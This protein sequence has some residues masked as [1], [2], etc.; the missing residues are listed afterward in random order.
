V[1]RLVN[2]LTEGFFSQTF[3]PIPQAWPACECT[4]SF[5]VPFGADFQSFTSF[6]FNLVDEHCWPEFHLTHIL[7]HHPDQV[8]NWKAVTST[9]N[10]EK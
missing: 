10:S 1:S 7:L 8:C 3:V 4:G 6:L 9:A 5:F 2:I